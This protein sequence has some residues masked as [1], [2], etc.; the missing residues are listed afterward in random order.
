M[1]FEIAL[2]SVSPTVVVAG[3]V[4]V[5][6]VDPPSGTTVVENCELVGMTAVGAVYREVQPVA[7]RA[8]AKAPAAASEAT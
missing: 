1:T 2:T 6:M 3:R 4:K 5:E 8:N 7:V